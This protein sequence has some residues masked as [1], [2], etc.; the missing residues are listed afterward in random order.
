MKVIGTMLTKERQN[1]IMQLLTEMQTV[2]LKNILDAVPASEST[3]RRDLTEMEK[4]GSLIRLHGGATIAEHKLQELTFTEK[5]AK[6]IQEKE[7][8]ARYAATL[9]QEED[10]I[11]LDAGSTVIQMVP[12]LT[13]KDIVV[14]TNGLTHTEALMKHGITTYLA[15]GLVKTKTSAVIGQQT[16]ETLNNYRFDKCFL[17]VNGFHPAYGYTTPDPEEAAVKRAAAG[18]ARETYVLADVSKYNRTSFA[19]VFD[20]K[21]AKLI[22]DK[23]SQTDAEKLREKTIVKVAET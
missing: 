23:I 3:I 6:N 4:Q 8:I 14:V 20:L 1:I 19:K 21:N 18:L 10:C 13:D 9:V 16:I 7:H 2:S 22:T 17:G 11:F 5:S 15:G 12:F